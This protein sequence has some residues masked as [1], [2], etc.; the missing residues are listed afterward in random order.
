LLLIEQQGERYI[1]RR[2]SKAD[3]IGQQDASV[4]A[5]ASHG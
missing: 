5:C 4:D 3:T 2:K 1:D